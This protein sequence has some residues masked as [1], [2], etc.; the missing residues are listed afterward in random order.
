MNI[1]KMMQQAKAMQDK[2][3]E[4]QEALSNVEVEGTSGG[5]LVKAVM[6]CKGEC[7]KIEI[8]PSLMKDDEKEIVEDLVKAAINDAK[9]K[10]D[11][12]L[13]EETQK[14]MADL[15]LPAGMNLPF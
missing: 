2:M 13:A 5:G 3:Q 6:T 4:M 10:A 7:R 9:S 1:Q 15:G 11:A 14:M 12:K 8:D